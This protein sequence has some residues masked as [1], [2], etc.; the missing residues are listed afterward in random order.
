VTKFHPPGFFLFAV[1]KESLPCFCVTAEQLLFVT[2]NLYRLGLLFA[3]LVSA[4]T[5]ESAFIPARPPSLPLAVKSPYLSTWLPAGQ[6]GG[7]GGYLAGEWPRFW[8]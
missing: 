4:V 2:M 8:E 7:N 1:Q 6:D 5:A 3:S